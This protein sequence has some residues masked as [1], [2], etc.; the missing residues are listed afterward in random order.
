MIAGQLSD[1]V[2]V[3]QLSMATRYHR[4]VTKAINKDEPFVNGKDRAF[5]RLA[6]AKDQFKSTSKPVLAFESSTVVRLL[7]RLDEKCMLTENGM[8]HG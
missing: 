1:L 4:P 3:W 2:A 7:C 6:L 8:L 5:W